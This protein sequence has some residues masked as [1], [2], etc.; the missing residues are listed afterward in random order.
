MGSLEERRAVRPRVLFVGTRERSVPTAS[1]DLYPSESMRT[2]LGEAQFALIRAK[3]EWNVAAG[4]DGGAA[5][6]V[7]GMEPPPLLVWNENASMAQR[8]VLESAVRG[9]A[10]AADAAD[11]LQSVHLPT[12]V[13]RAI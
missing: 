12:D 2:R 4:A 7:A 9:T 5:A 8:A 6:S 11:G 3:A 1:T 10:D 13:L